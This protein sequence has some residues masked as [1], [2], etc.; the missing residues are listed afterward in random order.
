M[1]EDSILADLAEI[2]LERYREAM[3][4]ALTSMGSG[5]ERLCAALEALCSQAEEN[6]ELLLALR[7]STD[8]V[9]HDDDGPEALTRSVFTEPFERLLCDG[10]KDGTVRQ[11]DVAETATVLFNLVGWTYIHLRTGHRWNPERARTRV[12]ETALHG[13]LP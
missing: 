7:S 12:L 2:A 9:F 13:V 5:A 1:D 4:P 3:W 6:M 8:A 10:I 11:V